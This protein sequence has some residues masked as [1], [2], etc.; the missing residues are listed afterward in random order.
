MRATEKQ[1]IQTKRVSWY[2]WL[3]CYGTATR[4][5]KEEILCTSVFI[6]EFGHINKS[7][8]ENLV[9]LSN[10]S[11]F[12]LSYLLWLRRNHWVNGNFKYR[13]SE[14]TTGDDLGFFFELFSRDLSYL[15]WYASI[16]FHEI[17]ERQASIRSFKCMARC[18]EVC[19]CLV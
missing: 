5:R 12:I 16:D 8:H 4:Q 19:V 15:H 14:G 1:T 9:V 11:F 18:P 17:F 2:I 3:H 10:L 7:C 13:A 6:A